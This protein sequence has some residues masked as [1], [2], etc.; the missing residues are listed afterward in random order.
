[1]CACVCVCVLLVQEINKIVLGRV[2]EKYGEEENF[3]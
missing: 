2:S 1:V 3:V